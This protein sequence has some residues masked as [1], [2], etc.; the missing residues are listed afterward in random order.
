MYL[1]ILTTVSELT[2]QKQQSFISLSY[3]IINMYNFAGIYFL[4]KCSIMH[5]FVDTKFNYKST[6]EWKGNDCNQTKHTLRN[7]V[8]PQSTVSEYS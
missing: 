2:C 6:A 7:E 3:S 4:N 5:I 1:F 8:G